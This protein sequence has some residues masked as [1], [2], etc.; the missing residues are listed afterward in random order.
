[1]KTKVQQFIENK[2]NSLRCTGELPAGKVEKPIKVN[3]IADARRLLSKIISKLQTG[4][5]KGQDAKDMTYL[6][7]NYVRIFK[8]E[9][10]EKWLSELEEKMKEYK[11]EEYFRGN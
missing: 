7:I 2:A 8:D 11:S 10:F 9:E 5:I 4:E 3:K 1:M 6:L